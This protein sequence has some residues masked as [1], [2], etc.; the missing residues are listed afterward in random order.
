MKYYFKKFIE[1]LYIRYVITPEVE[2]AMYLVK[3]LREDDLEVTFVPDDEFE[4]MI[5]A[6]RPGNTKH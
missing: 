5:E 2:M 1:W 6:S 4:A 3:D